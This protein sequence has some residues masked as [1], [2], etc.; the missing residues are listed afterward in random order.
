MLIL[1]RRRERLAY[2][3]VIACVVLLGLA[4][5]RPGL[6][7]PWLLAKYGGSILWGTMVYFIVAFFTPASDFLRKA[8]TAA[9]IAVLVELI[10]LYHVPWLDEFRTT[11]AGLLILGRYFSLLNILAYWVGIAL[12][13]LGDKKL[14]KPAFDKNLIS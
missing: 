12:G 3:T 11:T 7:L 10:R 14:C 6:G 9:S 13:T 8:A 1:N 5:R 4:W 2:A